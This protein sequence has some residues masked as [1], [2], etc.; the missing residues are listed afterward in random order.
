[1]TPQERATVGSLSLLYSFRMLGLCM[2][3]PLLALYARGLPGAG[4]VTIGLALGA[5]GLSQALLQIPLGWLSDQI[6]RKTVIIGGLLV[7]AL[8]SAVA[9][10][11][12]TVYGIIAG[13]VLQG[14]GAIAS[15]V[16]ALLADLTGEEQRTKAMAIVGMS[17]GLSFAVALVLGPLVAAAGGLGTV[18]WFNALLALVGIVIVVAAVPTPAHSGPHDEVGVRTGLVGHSLADP[19]LR[20][21]YFAVFSLHFLLVGLFLKIPG[22]LQDVAGLDV[23]HHWA[24]YLPVLALSIVAMVPMMI[25]AERRKHLHGTFLVA[26]SLLLLSVP[27]T[28]FAP[29]AAVLYLGLWLFFTGFNYLEATLPSLVS[30]VVS[31]AGKGTAMGIFSTCQYLGFFAGGAAG[32]WM[33]RIGGVQA[34]AA[35]CVGLAVVWWLVF[36]P[37]G[38]LPAPSPAGLSE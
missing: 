18:F 34:L 8:G 28:L 13:R 38:A 33:V 5:Y 30:K 23:D 35:C 21:L 12:H 25:M 22:A 11:S 32:G 27:V 19:G 7:F 14:S 4:P 3:T 1:M 10:L 20:R 29:R 24:V 2:V 36:L 26:I 37:G 17:I 6:G 15:T 16:M 9:A 31:P